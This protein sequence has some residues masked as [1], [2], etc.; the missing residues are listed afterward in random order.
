M[1]SLE[2]R[3]IPPLAMLICAA[4]MWGLARMTPDMA[5]PD[6]LRTSTWRL[7]L[8]AGLVI[9]G[10]AAFH[11]IRARTTINPMKP[12][13]ANA[14]VTTGL[15]RFSRNPI[16]VA[17]VLFL[18]AWGVYLSN[19]FSLA[20]T[21][22]FILYINRFQIIPEERALEENFGQEYRNYKSRVRRWI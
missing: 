13:T 9:M 17:D 6:G 10:V 20:L 15:Y 14:L 8:A 11:F 5:L 22:G 16:Y 4:L 19:P 21:A 7:L 2:L 3:I 1:K 18:L 12:E